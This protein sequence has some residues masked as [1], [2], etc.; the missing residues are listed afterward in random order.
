M[1]TITAV[2]QTLEFD[3][4]DS[5]KREVQQYH[6][7]TWPD[8]GVPARSSALLGFRY[9]IHTRHQATGGPLVVHCR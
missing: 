1:S 7:L 4:Q 3:F 2:I 9:K 8:R 5:E 6:Y